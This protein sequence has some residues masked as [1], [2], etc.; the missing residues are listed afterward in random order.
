MT[1]LTILSSGMVT[2]VGFGAAQTIASIAAG[3]SRYEESSIYNR[4][5]EPMTLALVPDDLLD[6][7]VD[8][9]A[10]RGMT[11]RQAR[12]LRLAAP[13]LVEA[14]EVIPEAVTPPSAGWPVFLAGPEPYEERPSALPGDSV[15]DWLTL[16]SGLTI[17]TATSQYFGVGRAGIFAA[18]ASAS[19]F[20]ESSPEGLAIIG[21]ADSYLDLVLLATL[22][23]D[24]RVLASGVM[25]GFA[26]GEGAAFLVVSRDPRGA[27]AR[28]LKPG[29]ADEPGYRGSDEPYRGEGLDAALRVALEAG[30]GPVAHVYASFNG[31]S[32]SSK[33]WGVAA[34]RHASRF[35]EEVEM[36]HPADC[37]GDP[38]AAAGAQLIALAALESAANAERGLSLVWSSS[39]G[40]LRGACLVAP[41]A[42]QS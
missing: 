16:Q 40:P 38:G 24:Q 5:F 31:E 18:L 10:S 12:I 21:G 3:L 7:L 29:L 14:V 37:Y 27:G 26:P 8:E 9:L 28:L 13:A 19:T 17:D 25:D 33:E 2:P 20:I 32:F 42:A 6:P 41:P 35:L 4:N 34:V 22:D 11:S 39:E 15:F 23:R 36:H 30:P 1:E